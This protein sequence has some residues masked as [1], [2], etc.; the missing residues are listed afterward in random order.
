MANKPLPSFGSLRNVRRA[1]EILRQAQVVLEHAP[2]L[3]EIRKAR[4]LSRPTG[5]L[6]PRLC[7]PHTW[8]CDHASLPRDSI[9]MYR[10]D[11]SGYPP[12]KT[13]SDASPR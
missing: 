10:G 11:S 8:G 3:E 12:S 13:S 7:T 4:E 1:G 2:S 5:L 6:T 9:L